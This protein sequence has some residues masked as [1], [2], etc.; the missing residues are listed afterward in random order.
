M[1]NATVY[2]LL[3]LSGEDSLSQ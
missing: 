2:G 1:S 3:R